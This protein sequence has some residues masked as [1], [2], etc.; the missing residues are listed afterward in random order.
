MIED[1]IELVKQL[2]SYYLEQFS[3]AT[4][5]TLAV[6]QEEVEIIKALLVLVGGRETQ[7]IQVI[8]WNTARAYYPWMLPACGG[9]PFYRDGWNRRGTRGSV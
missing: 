8:C 2:T 3:Q 6:K 5:P 4:C 1:Y 7:E 9:F